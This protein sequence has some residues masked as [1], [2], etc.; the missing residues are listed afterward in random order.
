MLPFHR[1][2]IATWLVTGLMLCLCMTSA[3][4]SDQEAAGAEEAAAPAQHVPAAF[5]SPHSTLKTF[6]EAM[7]DD[8]PD[9]DRAVECMDVSEVVEEKAPDLALWLYKCINRIEWVYFD[10]RPYRKDPGLLTA[11]QLDAGDHSYTLFP[12]DVRDA[13]WIDRAQYERARE[14]AGPDASIV[15]VRT[16][17]GA[18][19]FSAETVAGIEPLWDSLK[20]LPPVREFQGEEY[21]TLTERLESLWPASLRE[22]RFL[23]IEYWQWISLFI[24][25][26][27]GLVLDL[28]IRLL[29]AIISR[30]V[31]A[32]RG[33]KTAPETLRRTV[34]PFGLTAAALLWLWTIR[35]LGLPDAAWMVLM[36]A[37]R[38]FAMLAVVWAAY[39]LTDLLG[40]F[41]ASKASR[42]ETKFDDLLIPLVR[43]T[44]KIFI[45]I[46]GLIY[47]ADS[48]HISI[49]PLLTGLG[50]GGVGFAFAAKDTLEHFFGSVTVIADRPFQVGDWV[51]IDGTEGTVEEVGFRSTRVRTF[52]NSLVTIPNGNLVRAVVDNF[53]QRKYRRY[54]TH[55]SITYDTP[56]EKIE[57]FCEGIRELVRLHPYTRKDYYQVWLHEF[58]AHSLDVLLYVFWQTPDWQTELRERHRLMLDVIRLADRMGIEFAFPTQT[59]HLYKEEHDAEHAPAEAPG[60]GAELVAE[61]SG[62][63]EARR[64]T[65]AATWRQKKPPP[66]RFRYAG[67]T[68]EDDEDDDTQIESKV[69][70]DA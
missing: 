69:G 70:G 61:R 16:D 48:M 39:R 15:I 68:S 14:L 67:E 24:L 37:A 6:L 56:P 7:G 43:K 25:I 65:A 3:G 9:L 64:L 35:Y 46:F 26:L 20:A 54:S 11:D 17:S 66:Y 13:R 40:E 21:L 47:I 60:R 45:A 18:W 49:V 22:G 53:G 59:L 30:R 2:P 5:D 27:I 33:G 50:I 23:A 44:I 4:Q 10:D 12:R 55:V 29:L 41:F 8:P 52:Y 32:R 28:I 31:I 1:C 42:T 57:A 58:G 51:L 36:A 62:R 38:L 19:K 34:R 63:A